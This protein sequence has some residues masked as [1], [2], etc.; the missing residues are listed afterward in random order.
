MDEKITKTRR[1]RSLLAESKGGM[2][3][4]AIATILYGDDS[5]KSKWRTRGLLNYIRR[6]EREKKSGRTYL[7]SVDRLHQ[8]L[9]SDNYIECSEEHKKRIQSFL[10]ITSNLIIDGIIK[11]PG[12]ARKL[13]AKFLE[14]EIEFIQTRKNLLINYPDENNNEEPPRLEEGSKST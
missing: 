8:F 7:Y 4:S 10:D 1:L 9:N 3:I 6:K 11:Y 12:L 13:E 2:D 14:I 5:E